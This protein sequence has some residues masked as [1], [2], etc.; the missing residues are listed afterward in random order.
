MQCGF[1]SNPSLLWSDPNVHRVL[2]TRQ[3][4]TLS[5]RTGPGLSPTLETYFSFPSTL[6][7]THR[8][9]LLPGECA[10]LTFK[11]SLLQGTF[12]RSPSS[13]RFPPLWAFTGAM[14]GSNPASAHWRGLGGRQSRAPLSGHEEPFWTQFCTMLTPKA[15]ALPSPST[16]CGNTWGSEGRSPPLPE[17]HTSWWLGPSDPGHPLQLQGSCPGASRPLPQGQGVCGAADGGSPQTGRKAE[18]CLVR[19]CIGSE[20]GFHSKGRGNPL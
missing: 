11:H 10:Y 14:E 3:A 15:A 17:R 6:S 7:D 4:F 19:S 2:L 12:L 8:L 16:S 1:H 13:Q 5:S 20:F 9:C 18:G